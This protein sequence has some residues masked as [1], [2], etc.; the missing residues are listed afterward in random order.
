MNLI[1]QPAAA[2]SGDLPLQ[3]P[4]GKGKRSRTIFDESFIRKYGYHHPS[5]IGFAPQARLLVGRKDRSLGVWRM[6]E[7]EG[8]WGEGP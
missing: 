5:R 8:G 7:D 1:L 6:L 2:P 4:L 3:D